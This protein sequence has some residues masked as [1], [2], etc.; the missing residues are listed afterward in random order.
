MRS[1]RAFVKRYTSK[2]HITATQR[3]MSEN[4]HEQA[5]SKCGQSQ[6]IGGVSMAVI[7]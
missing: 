1:S 2:Q 3:I 5:E 6:V 7:F 4:E